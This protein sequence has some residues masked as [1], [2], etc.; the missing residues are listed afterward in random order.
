MMARTLARR[1]IVL[2][3]DLRGPRALKASFKSRGNKH[4]DISFRI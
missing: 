2:R 3:L 4:I 1:A